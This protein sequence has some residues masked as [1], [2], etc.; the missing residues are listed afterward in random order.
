MSSTPESHTPYKSRFFNFLNRRIIKLNSSLGITFRQFGQAINTGIATIIFPFYILLE[1][2]K[3]L[4]R[5]FNPSSRKD[6]SFSLDN[7]GGAPML[8][9]CDLIIEDVNKQINQFPQLQQLQSNQFQGLASSLENK[10]I[11]LVI[12]SNQIDISFSPQ[13][14]KQLSLIIRDAR[15]DYWDKK[16]RLTLTANRQANQL[17]TS[18]FTLPNPFNLFSRRQKVNQN[19]ANLQK[20][21]LSTVKKPQDKQTNIANFN[22]STQPSKIISFLDNVLM[23]IEKVTLTQSTQ[24]KITTK[25]KDNEEK[26]LNFNDNIL[27]NSRDKSSL[28]TLIKA[29]VDHFFGFAKKNLQT[30]QGDKHQGQHLIANQN[31]LSLKSTNLD[32]VNQKLIQVFEITQNTGQKIIPLIQAKTEQVIIKGLNQAGVIKK[33]LNNIIKPEDNPFNVQALIW[34]AVDYFFHD[35][36]NHKKSFIFSYTEEEVFL[37]DGQ[38]TDP[39]LSWQDLYGEETSLLSQKIVSNITHQK[40]DKSKKNNFLSVKKIPPPD[41]VKSNRNSVSNISTQNQKVGVNNTDID[42]NQDMEANV[43]TIGYEKHF[44]E[45]ILERLDQLMLWLE[46]LIIKFVQKYLKFINFKND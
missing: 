39:W 21:S 34:A 13:Q 22:N 9:H 31:T 24:E 33:R 38:I 37:L 27:D 36:L 17:N 42:I 35:K 43:I 3:K 32:S 16:R 10:Q 41:T 1:N 29:A 14:Q 28:M 8:P 40:I 46:E 2:G 44:L 19:L 7:S 30:L 6:S 23:R 45:V 18:K 26:S 15:G 25:G 4:G 11:V 5:V 12:T 20:S